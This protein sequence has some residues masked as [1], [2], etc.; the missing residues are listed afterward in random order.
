MFQLSLYKT[1]AQQTR[2]IYTKT[3]VHKQY[4]DT[5]AKLDNCF[6]KD[7]VNKVWDNDL[8]LMEY[9]SWK[10]GDTLFRIGKPSQDL[11]EAKM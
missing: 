11:L 5:T 8:F 3:V 4:L 2:M 6:L 7:K 9:L 10:S 1:L